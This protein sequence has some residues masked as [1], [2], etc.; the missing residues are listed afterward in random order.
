MLSKA[1]GGL[2]AY[3]ATRSEVAV[4]IADITTTAEQVASASQQMSATTT[5]ERRGHRQ[6]R[7]LSATV[8]E[9]ASRQVQNIDAARGINHEAEALVID[10][11]RLARHG[12]ALTEQISAVADQTN[13]LALNAAIEAARAGEQG[14]GFAVVADEVRKLA[15]SSDATARETEAAFHTLATSIADLSACIQRM[16]VATAEVVEIAHQAGDATANVSA[17]TEQSSAAT[18]QISAS[19]EDLAQMAEKMRALVGAFR[20]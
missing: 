1:Q 8:A 18:E 16:S 13:L 11:G 3:N 20:A 5:R 10:A 19:S 4:I 15:E 2:Q 17:A 14:R 9:G 12:V 7:A 6:H